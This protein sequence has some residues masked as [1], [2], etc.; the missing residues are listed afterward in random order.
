MVEKVI[1]LNSLLSFRMSKTYQVIFMIVVLCMSASAV[2]LRKRDC[3]MK[4]V[5]AHVGCFRTCANALCDDCVSS[6]RSCFNGCGK[7]R[8]K[9]VFEDDFDFDEV[10]A[11]ATY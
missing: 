5:G 3:I 11:R 4:C 1:N 6:R 8:N 10:D 7:K 9:I 2:E